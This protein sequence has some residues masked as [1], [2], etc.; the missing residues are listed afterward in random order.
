MTGRKRSRYVLWAFVLGVNLLVVEVVRGKA[1]ETRTARMRRLEYKKRQ[2]ELV[3]AHFFSS[4]PG[5]SSRCVYFWSK[6]LQLIYVQASILKKN[7]YLQSS[8]FVIEMRKT[9][10]LWTKY[11]SQHAIDFIRWIEY[12]LKA[13]ML[14]LRSKQIAKI[15]FQHCLTWWFYFPPHVVERQIG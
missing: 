3:S 13:V 4:Y 6:C 7:H 15:T 11:H 2:S 8:I 12:C 5:R 14:P 10:G 9:V 1:S